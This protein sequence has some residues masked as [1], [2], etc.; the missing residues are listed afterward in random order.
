MGEE[1]EEVAVVGVG[2]VVEALLEA[3]AADLSRMISPEIFS[4]F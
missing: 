2:G 1:A 3:R 4:R